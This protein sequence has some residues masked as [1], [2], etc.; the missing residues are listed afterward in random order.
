ME[1]IRVR[2]LIRMVFSVFFCL[3]ISLGGSDELR[4]ESSCVTCHTDEEMLSDNLGKKDKQ[5]SSLQAGPG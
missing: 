1:C 2:V 3:L 5:K 4:A